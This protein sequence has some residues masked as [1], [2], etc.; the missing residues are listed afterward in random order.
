MRRRAGR[1][2]PS[3]ASPGRAGVVAA[4]RR[5][6]AL[7]PGVVVPP[8]T[9]AAGAA[10]ASAAGAGPTSVIVI[11]MV[12]VGGGDVRTVVVPVPVAVCGFARR[13]C[14][15]R[16]GLR[17]RSRCVL[18]RQGRLLTGR[19]GR[20]GR[21][22]RPVRARVGVGVV[23]GAPGQQCD[24]QHQHDEASGPGLDLLGS[25]SLRPPGN[26]LGAAGV[27]AG[28]TVEPAPVQAG[29]TAVPARA[30][31]LRRLPAQGYLSGQRVVGPGG[32]GGSTGRHWGLSDHVAHGDCAGARTGE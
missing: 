9:S 17:W 25:R 20:R 31:G 2:R 26:V 15:C 10:T 22:V 5:A 16:G 13:S 14:R 27:S 18:R 4:S 30:A 23:A 21:V 1:A 19:D 6:A 3:A 29:V 12:D 24:E 11:V 32:R 8:G 28:A 7:C